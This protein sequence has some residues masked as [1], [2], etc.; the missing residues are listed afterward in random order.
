MPDPR[1]IITSLI[2]AAVASL[3]LILPVLFFRGAGHWRLKNICLH[4]SIGIP[5]LIYF[6]AVNGFPSLPRLGSYRWVFFLATMAILLGI[7]D[8]LWTIPMWIRVLIVLAI[9]EVFARILVGPAISDDDSKNQRLMLIQVFSAI[10]FV[11]WI[12][13]SVLAARIPGANIAFALL[14]SSVAIPFLIM[15]LHA[16]TIGQPGLIV[17]TSLLLTWPIVF[18]EAISF[19]RGPILFWLIVMLGILAGSHDFI[20]LPPWTWLLLI[21]SPQMA[22]FSELRLFRQLPPIVRGVIGLLLAAIPAL[23]AAGL[24]YSEFMNG[25]SNYPS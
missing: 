3:V 14:P 15:L 21:V 13:L 1:Q 18:R 11:S 6:A 12:G 8:A 20:T 17:S 19:A 22:W 10:L 24:A 9:A 4:L 7:V 25:N 5:F 2:P 23:I 16:M